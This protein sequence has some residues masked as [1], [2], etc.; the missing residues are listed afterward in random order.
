MDGCI[1][2]NVQGGEEGTCK[3]VERGRAVGGSTDGDVKREG[4]RV[5]GGHGGVGGGNERVLAQVVAHTLGVL[6]HVEAHRSLGVEKDKRSR[7][8]RKTREEEEMRSEAE[9]RR[10]KMRREEE[11]REEEEETRRE[12]E[13]REEEED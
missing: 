5:A 12:Q 4:V 13:K 9:K 11:T 3:D 10:E 1:C 8:D 7:E 6:L 2:M